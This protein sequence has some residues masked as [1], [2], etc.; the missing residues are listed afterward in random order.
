MKRIKFIV[1]DVDGTLTDG[2]I[3][4]GENGELFKTFDVKDGYAIK[5]MLP[6]YGLIPIIITA[7]SSRMLEHRCNELDI[8]YVYQ[9]V[10]DKRHKLMEILEEQGQ[11]DNVD[12]SYKDCA[13]IGDD[14]LDLQCMKP[15]KD[16]GGLAGCP[17]DAVQEVKAISDYV[18]SKNGGDGAVRE[19]IE[20]VISFEKETK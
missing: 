15:I 6:E 5:D 14:I 16:A 8:E 20:W 18:C 2:K 3:H 13:Y 7:R 11:Q 9:G 10:R 12:Y 19:F 4:M 17:A 1:M